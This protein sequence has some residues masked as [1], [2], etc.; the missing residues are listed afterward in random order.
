MSRVVSR[1]PLL[2]AAASM[3]TLRVAAA[4]GAPLAI[5]YIRSTERRQPLSLLDAQ[6]RDDGLAG[7]KLAMADNTTTGRFIGQS[8]ELRDA[9]VGDSDDAVAALRDL[10]ASG[11]RLALTDLPAPTILKLADAGRTAGVTLFNVAAPDDS[12][13]ERDCRGNVI[14]VAP[15][16]TMLA[17]AL[18][19][20]LVW[21]R[22]S[23]W[24]LLRGPAA[25]DEALAAAYRR[26]A[27]RFGARVV[28]D[29]LFEDVEGSHQTD[30]GLLQMQQQMPVATQNA[31]EYDVLVVADELLD[32]AVNLPYRTWDPRPVAGSAG[33][34]PVTWS[35]AS[36]SWGGTQLQDRF[37]RQFRR[38]M[39]PLDMQAWTACRM[40]GEAATRANSVEPDA[41]MRFMRGPDFAVAAYK[42]QPLTLRDWNGQLRQP[43]LLADGRSVV[44]VSPQP[45]FLHPV[46]EL[47]TLGLD[48]PESTC[49]L[50]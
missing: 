41:V 37:V 21:K 25:E 23:R 48:R 2:G 26:A 6:A 19:Q 3:L 39:T 20:Y 40:I 12:L 27:R 7:A 1:R 13:R 31:R 9:G 42:G 10:S 11:V 35:P 24:F 36:E 30:T 28:E 5:G 49:K 38:T 8:Y 44:S 16:R 14:H 29:R 46:S 45:G 17:D 34:R 43:I 50:T 47:D 33:L 18:A 15:T 4:E 22:W 32:F